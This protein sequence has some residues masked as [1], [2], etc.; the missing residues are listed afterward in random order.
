[1]TMGKWLLFVP[2]LLVT[3][4]AGWKWSKHQTRDNVWFFAFMILLS[5]IM[6]SVVVL[7]IRISGSSLTVTMGQ[8]KTATKQIQTAKKKV[9][10]TK[11]DVEEIGKLIFKTAFV[12][13][14]GS[15]RMRGVPPE[16]EAKL[17]E[18]AKEMSELTGQDCV[19]R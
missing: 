12:L 16:H 19:S 8:I 1:M 10:A 17:K 15:H 5:V 4:F 9:L 3:F 11:Q 7:D 6:Y 13:S 14:E 18:Y 2:L